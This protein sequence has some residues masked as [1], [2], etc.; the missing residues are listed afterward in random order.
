MGRFLRRLQDEFGPCSHW[1]SV[2]LSW[3]SPR[4]R[5]LSCL[6]A[7]LWLLW[8][9]NPRAILAVTAMAAAAIMHLPVH[10]LKIQIRRRLPL[11]LR[12]QRT[13]GRGIR[14]HRFF[15]AAAVPARHVDRPHFVPC[16]TGRTF[17]LSGV[18]ARSYGET[19]CLPRAGLLLLGMRSTSFAARMTTLRDI[20]WSCWCRSSLLWS[21]PCRN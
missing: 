1:A 11:F 2:S 4:P 21:L 5:R 12:H 8:K 19:L 13:G 20:S 9:K 7:I 16:R 14:P 17:A 3:C 15:P 18:V 10:R 6:P